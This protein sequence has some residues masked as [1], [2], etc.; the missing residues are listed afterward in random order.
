[1]ACTHGTVDPAS[2]FRLLQYVPFLEA[3]GWQVSHRPCVP[4]RPWSSAQSFR[5]LKVVQQRAQRLRR[6]AHRWRDVRDAARFDAVFLNRDLLNGDPRWEERLVRRNP[7]VVFDFDD[8]VYEAAGGRQAEWMCRHAAW[9]TAG[10]ETL[11]AWARQFTE[12]VSVLPTVVDVAVYEMAVGQ[13]GRRVGW[14]GSPGS[15]E[16]TLIPFLPMLAR[17]QRE[18]GF[19]FVVMTKPRPDIDAPGLRWAYVEWN[20]RDERRLGDFFDIGLMPMPDT[21]FNRGKCGLKIL[22]YMA[23]GLSFIASPVG[24]NTHMAG[25]GARGFLA[26]DE[27]AWRHA[28]SRLLGNPD[29]GAAVGLRGRAFCAGHYDLR[30]W[31]PVLSDILRCA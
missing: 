21:P 27:A 19:E 30:R 12:R 10:N 25:D 14:C 6:A 15:I 28:L 4:A 2:R 1:M 18:L 16:M 3:L 13:P 9:V 8:A 31:V 26:A 22:Q 5:P 17:L 23:C 7:R 29:L 24:V 11:A 20:E